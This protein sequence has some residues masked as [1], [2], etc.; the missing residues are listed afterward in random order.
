[1]LQP[2]SGNMA[3][4]LIDPGSWS[5]PTAPCY[6]I[7]VCFPLFHARPHAKRSLGS[8]APPTVITIVLSLRTKLPPTNTSFWPTKK[9]VWPLSIL[10]MLTSSVLDAACGQIWNMFF[11]SILELTAPE[12]AAGR[13]FSVMSASI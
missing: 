10:D 2:R 6:W 11:W 3:S 12:R 13:S 4:M 7:S 5:A 9:P 8:T 1:M